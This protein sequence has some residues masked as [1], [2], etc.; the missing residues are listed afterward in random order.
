V[1][2]PLLQ[3]HKLDYVCMHVIVVEFVVSDLV[4]YSLNVVNYAKT[5]Q[6]VTKL[7]VAISFN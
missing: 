2:F 7:V 1:L 5:L 3:L 6:S 4:H